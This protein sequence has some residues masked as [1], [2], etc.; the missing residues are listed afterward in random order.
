MAVYWTSGIKSASPA[1][2]QRE[3]RELSA[4][5]ACVTEFSIRIYRLVDVVF[6]VRIQKRRLRI[7]QAPPHFQIKWRARV[8]WG[9]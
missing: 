6:V 2:L 3:L 8:A 5:S 4:K 7:A 1:V 9:R